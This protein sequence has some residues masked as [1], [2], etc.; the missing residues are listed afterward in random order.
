MHKTALQIYEERNPKD[1]LLEIVGNE[2]VTITNIAP[3]EVCAPGDMVFALNQKAVD[4]ALT[5]GASLIVVPKNLNIP[6]PSLYKDIAII[7]SSN[8]G[9]SHAR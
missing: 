1:A 6:I 3:Y 4:Q 9:V 8:I 5:N 2:Q 7:S